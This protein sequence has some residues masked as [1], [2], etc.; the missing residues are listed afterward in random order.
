MILI[1]VLAAA[2]P[3]WARLP[4]PPPNPSDEEL[5]AGREAVNARAAEVGSLSLQVVELDRQAAAAQEDLTVKREAAFERLLELQAA[6]DAADEATR[7]VEAAGVESAAAASASAVAQ[8]QSDLVAVATY[9]QTLDLGP[10]GLL[11]EARSLEDL[12]A[13]AEFTDLVAREQ[14][15]ALDGLLRAGVEKVNAESKARAAEEEALRQRE[16]ADRARVAAD[17]ALAVAVA[18]AAQQEA[19]LQALSAQR[20]ELEQRL[21]SARANER[22]LLSQRERYVEYQRRAAEVA[23]EERRRAAAAAETTA[24][25]A[26]EPQERLAPP[27]REID[28]AAAKLGPQYECRGKVPRWGPVK[29]WVSAA[30][31]LLRCRFGIKSVDGVGPRPN[32]SDHPA[33][34]AQDFFVDRATGDALADCALRNQSRLAIKYVIY[35]QRINS[36]SGWRMMADRGGPVANHMEHVHISFRPA[37]GGSLAAVR[38]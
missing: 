19:Q 38:C 33:G 12:V 16:V 37:P 15:R 5:R 32:V 1:F 3:A 7:R 6:Q 20:A 26:A 30:G 4:P 17:D 28:G 18:A 27:P 21:D 36:G 9:Q 13:R 10:L 14:Q 31:Q 8:E 24:R 35:R 25:A 2:P 23:E 34:L 29:P 22:G 11:T